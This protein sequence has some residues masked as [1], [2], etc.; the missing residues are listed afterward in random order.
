MEGRTGRGKLRRALCLLLA[1]AVAVTPGGCTR[2]FYRKSAD[3]EVQEVLADKDRYPLWSIQQY[4]VYPDPRAR[5]ADPTNPDRPPM[6]PD[7]PAAE[8]LAPIPQKPGKAGTAYIENAGFLELLQ[9]WDAENRAEQ[10]RRLREK[11]KQEGETA[12]PPRPA[13]PKP[14]ATPL[15]PGGLPAPTPAPTTYG[16][17]TQAPEGVPTY[18]QSTFKESPDAPRPFLLTV[19]NAAELGLI[20]SREFQDRREDLYLTALPVTQ[21]RFAFAYQFFLAEQI[22]RERTGRLTP[23][24]Q[25][26]RYRFNTDSGFSK[27]F[28][29]GALLLFGFANRTVVELTGNFPKHTVSTSTI[30]LDLI[31]PLLQGGGKAVTLEPLTQTERNLLYEVRD[32]ARFRKQF[33][34]GIA[35]GADISGGFSAGFG[36]GGG[37][38]GLP[39]VLSGV[40]PQVGPGGIS[41][42]LGVSVGAAPEGFLP[43]LLRTSQLANERLNIA[44]LSSFLVRFQ[45]FL[46]GGEIS[47]LNLDQVEQ[48]LLN[49]VTSALTQEQALRDSLDRFKLQLGLPVNIPIALDDT[50]LRAPIEQTDRYQRVVDDFDRLRDRVGLAFDLEPAR[51]R[52]FLR[53][54]A[55]DD[56]AVRGTRFRETFPRVWSVWEQLPKRD[57]NRDPVFERLKTLGDERIKLLAEKTELELK[58][59]ELSEA[60]RKRLAEVLFDVD[61]GI[62]EGALRAYEAEPWKNEADPAEQV[63][64]KQFFFRNATDSF[65][66]LLSAARDERLAQLR[67]SWPPLPLICV[68]GTNLVTA[69]LDRAEALAALTAVNNRF[70]LMTARAQLHDSWRKIAVFANSLLG[71]F[72]VQYHLDSTTPPGQ[73][74]P[75][76]FTGSRARNQL[77]LN[78]ELPLVRKLERNGYRSS[79]IAYQRQRRA[80]MA[81]EDV[82]ANQVRSEIR[83]LRVLAEN[84][85]IQKRQVELAYLQ[86]ENSLE[87]FDQPASPQGGGGTSGNAFSLTQQLLQAQSGKLRAQNTLYSIW[88]NYQTVRLQLYRDLE[89]M[90]LDYRG[91]WIDELANRSE[92]PPSGDGRPCDLSWQPAAQRPGDGPGRQRG[93]AG[94]LPPPAG[95][96]P[97]GQP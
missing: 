82:I 27:L 83:Q 71:V 92:C 12:P 77:I 53:R 29:T 52:E 51:L 1:V 75:V 8:S 39:G 42:N 16:P 64:R 14:G 59:Q 61:V 89:L 4:H 6:P 80:L 37:G 66:Q 10:E 30:N 26:N 34:V 47:R 22:I 24:G 2:R 70:D 90:P 57:A 73:A 60:K 93:A 79:L 20:N 35:A 3:N 9:G 28:P 31:Q 44:A 97:G 49:S 33:Y 94:P 38:G 86:V 81:T 95:P 43:T 13:D 63:R 72:D 62:F 40:T 45:N 23:E 41:F 91:V 25:H 96:A 54:A 55:A 65:V 32:F 87:Q 15:G 18:G 46:E 74:K 50:P 69:D 85:N 84:Y 76:A 88:I 68:D 21:Q 36:G 7:D 48:N 67:E 11:Q 5:F 58:D 19:E 56:P 17:P 78:T